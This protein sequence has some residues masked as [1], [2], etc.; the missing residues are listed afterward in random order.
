MYIYMYV[1]IIY[2]FMWVICIHACMY[3]CMCVYVCVYV[4][5]YYIYIH[6]GNMYTCMCMYM[7]VCMYMQNG[8]KAAD[9]ARQQGH[10]A[11][12]HV[13]SDG[14]EGTEGGTAPHDVSTS[15]TDETI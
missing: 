4:C 3:V 15:S 9:V 8:D 7:C 6:V 5:V 14:Y 12:V 1:C 13:L 2:I 10:M 11:A